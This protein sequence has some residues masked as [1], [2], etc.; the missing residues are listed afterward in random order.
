M[1]P[2]EKYENP[3][4][5]HNNPR[6]LFTIFLI[7]VVVLAFLVITLQQIGTPLVYLNF[8]A[9]GFLVLAYPVVGILS[10]TMR[11]DEYQ[12][13]GRRSTRLFNGLAIASAG[14]TGTLFALFA[15]EVYN[16][17]LSALTA[18][19][20]A[21]LGVS[22]ASLIFAPEISRNSAFTLPQYIVASQSGTVSGYLLR[23]LTIIIIAA[24]SMLLVV[25]QLNLAQYVAETF[26]G[27]SPQLTVILGLCAVLACLL[28]GGIRGL[29]WIRVGFYTIAAIAFLT[30]IIWLSIERTGI[31]FPQ[32]SYGSG[33]L[34]LLGNFQLE[35]ANQG[36][37]ASAKLVS[38]T[39]DKSGY[40]LLDYLVIIF[41]VG[42]GTAAMPNLLQHYAT[43]IKGVDARFSGN[44][45]VF[46]LFL[47]LSSVPAYAAFV[48][49][50]IYNLVV[51]LPLSELPALV[52]WLFDRGTF[53]GEP[54]VSICGVE[55]TS[56]KAVSQA[57][58]DGQPY[59]L[60]PE[61]FRIN[62]AMVVLESPNV[63][64]LPQ[65]L[66]TLLAVGVFAAI[67]STIDG[68]LLLASN[69][70]A[71]DGYHRLIRST[72][73][74]NT[75]LFVSRLV[76]VL[77]TIAAGYLA[78]NNTIPIGILISAAIALIAVGLFPALLAR[79][80]WP[81]CQNGIVLAGSFA[82]LAAALA[83]AYSHILG[84][85]F[86]IYSG[87]EF[88]WFSATGNDPFPFLHS[89]FFGMLVGISV[90]F[91]MRYFRKSGEEHKAAGVE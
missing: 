1:H 17:G 52:P 54:L 64:D 60:A 85:D 46:F 89:G 91:V 76:L 41:C 59:V 48:K 87:D 8:M 88:T 26:Y 73:P 50:D 29:T 34:Q 71:Y 63:T 25:S 62:G 74:D 9:L 84:N 79:S 40:G 15:G 27:L 20:A 21:L 19:S 35:L 90:M 2:M 83:H 12:L 3:V 53:A 10:R 51:G 81:R 67:F 7:S 4:A 43:N 32:I 14:F 78:M 42:A 69:S 28:P 47:V 33:A 30:P 55:A 18:I 36:F 70:L 45:A 56:L 57:C 82:G 22:F 49:L 37:E 61:D 16:T 75:I 58:A 68:L 31:P 44:W 24:S 77:I 80:V 23:V 39:N 65:L 11:L 86:E 38:I 5:A 72:S 13:A 66:K 6:Q